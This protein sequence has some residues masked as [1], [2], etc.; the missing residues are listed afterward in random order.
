MRKNLV[1]LWVLFGAAMIL[2]SLSSIQTVKGFEG[3][4]AHPANLPLLLFGGV[5]LFV[6]AGLVRK[7]S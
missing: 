5:A 4:P 2:T 3:C 7:Y 1:V 6:I